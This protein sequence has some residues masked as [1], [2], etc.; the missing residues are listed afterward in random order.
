MLLTNA[1]YFT[2]AKM[3]ELIKLCHKILVKIDARTKIQTQIFELMNV[4]IKTVNGGIIMVEYKFFLTNH[5]IHGHSTAIFLRQHGGIHFG[6]DSI[7]EARVNFNPALDLFG[8]QRHTKIEGEFERWMGIYCVHFFVSHWYSTLKN[9]H[10]F[11]Q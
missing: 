10:F 5:F 7:I 4:A 6:V 3:I 1:K 11:H 8:Y 9:K 2:T